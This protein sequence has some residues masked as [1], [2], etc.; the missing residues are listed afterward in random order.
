MAP[1]AESLAKRPERA[2]AL[3]DSRSLSTTVIRD[4][5]RAR[6]AQNFGEFCG[7]L[8]IFLLYFKELSGT[9]YEL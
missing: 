1:L 6:S 4:Q 8:Y 3:D 7:I 9:L 2:A 5:K